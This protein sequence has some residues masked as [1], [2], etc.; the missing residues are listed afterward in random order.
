MIDGN[1]ETIV[2]IT[3]LS[4]IILFELFYATWV[5]F[6]TWYGY[7]SSLSTIF[8][9][10]QRFSEIRRQDRVF[11]LIMMVASVTKS[12]LFSFYF[13]EP[14]LFPALL[15]LGFAVPCGLLALSF[16]YV[17]PGERVLRIRYVREIWISIE[18]LENNLIQ[19]WEKAGD[20]LYSLKKGSFGFEDERAFAL[21]LVTRCPRLENWVGPVPDYIQKHPYYLTFTKNVKKTTIEELAE[22]LEKVSLPDETRP[23]ALFSPKPGKVRFL[24]L[25]GWGT[26][27]IECRYC[28]QKW[29]QCQYLPTQPEIS[30]RCQGCKMDGILRY[31]PATKRARNIK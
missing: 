28:G 20:L 5:L 2:A 22:R 23:P 10:L 19:W 4:G 16:H 18:K 11:W 6:F 21:V 31:N 27:I 14:F 15:L 25:R 17:Y 8:N 26:I 7:R 29:A 12:V 9:N 13:S 1:F 3:L 24:G 30:F